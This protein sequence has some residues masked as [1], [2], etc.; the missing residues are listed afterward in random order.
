M[1]DPQ[2]NDEKL[3][4]VSNLRETEGKIYYQDRVVRTM[5]FPIG[6]EP[7]EFQKLLNDE[8]V[9]ENV[10]TLVKSFEGKVVMVGVDR[11][12]YI[13]GI[14][15]KM[16][17]LDQFLTTY[18]QWKEKIVLLQLAIPTRP[19]VDAYQ[20]LRT[21]V[22]GLVSEINGKHGKCILELLSMPGT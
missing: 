7:D 6:I 12:D 15:Q 13:K 1:S 8:G 14:P 18:P 19:D 20:K 2:S 22:N 10:K 21:E 3:T 4:S 5:N 17:A 16:Q 9:K 11:M